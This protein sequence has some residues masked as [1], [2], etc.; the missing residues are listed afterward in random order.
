[1]WRPFIQKATSVIDTP[2]MIAAGSDFAFRG[3]T[4]QKPAGTDVVNWYLARVHGAASHDR[5]VCR[6][7]FDVANLLAPATA[8]FHPGIV[9]RVMKACLWGS[10]RLQTAGSDFGSGRPR[11][12]RSSSTT[13]P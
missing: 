13:S 10:A 8:L 11:T 7:F 12:A 4:G 1:V 6:T 2:W 3:V 5:V 9:R